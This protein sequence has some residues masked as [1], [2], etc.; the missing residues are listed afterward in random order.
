MKKE[1]PKG[2]S[3]TR[4]TKALIKKAENLKK[5]NEDIMLS[6]ARL[7]QEMEK[8]LEKYREMLGKELEPTNFKRDD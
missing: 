2:K 3:F 6:F 8:T 5:Q 1:R 7:G 4:E